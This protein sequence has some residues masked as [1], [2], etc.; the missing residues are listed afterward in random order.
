[1]THGVVRAGG[2]GS[3]MDERLVRGLVIAFIFGTV[4]LLVVFKISGVNVTWSDL[5]RIDPVVVIVALALVT[6]TWVFSLRMSALV[7]AIGETP[8]F[9]SRLRVAITGVFVASLMP[10]NAGGEPMQIY[11][12]RNEG[13]SVGQASAVVAAKTFCNALAKAIV[14]FTVSSWIVLSGIGWRVPRQMKVVL[15]TASL[16]YVAFFI[17]SLFL[18]NDPR[19]IET[20]IAPILRSRFAAK[21]LRHGRGERVL[22]AIRKWIAE[23]QIA[24]AHY[25][26]RERSTLL[27]VIYL[28]VAGWLA[29]V[30]VP[31]MIPGGARGEGAQR[32]G[33]GQRD[34][35]T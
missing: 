1:M 3:K 23:F 14:A 11:L 24:F 25:W 13:L 19:R 10:F 2:I 16:L 33:D 34:S 5:R 9:W 17:F 21:L 4:A 8:S 26:E 29:I 22:R 28:S 30:L 32:T 35:V 27:G 7:R 31:T 12:L 15:L 20:V 18:M 6:A